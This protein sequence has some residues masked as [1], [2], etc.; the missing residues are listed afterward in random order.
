MPLTAFTSLN[1]LY[2]LF[3]SITDISIVF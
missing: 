1:D 3:T 2:I